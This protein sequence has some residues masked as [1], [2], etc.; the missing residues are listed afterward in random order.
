MVVCVLCISF[1]LS[2]YEYLNM[3]ISF[4]HVACNCTV[5]SHMV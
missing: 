2:M 3:M 1:E 5:H 4:A